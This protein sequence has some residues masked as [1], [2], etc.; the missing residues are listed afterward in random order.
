MCTPHSG[1]N[2]EKVRQYLKLMSWRCRYAERSIQ[3]TPR[4]DDVPLVIT[5]SLR[6]MSVAKSGRISPF[7]GSDLSATTSI[8]KAAAQRTVV[9]AASSQSG[10]GSGLGSGLGSRSRSSYT[11]SSSYTA[12]GS[13]SR[14]SYTGSSSSSYT[15]ATG[16]SSGSYGGASASGVLHNH[17]ACLGIVWEW[18]TRCFGFI[19]W[20]RRL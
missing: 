19:L 2:L 17:H 8:T 14:S 16:S 13:G 7:D 11:G 9:S 3:P 20:C 15:T 10:S 18:S 1:C 12:T 5:S 4:L 6:Q